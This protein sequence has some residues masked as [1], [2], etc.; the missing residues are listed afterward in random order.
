MKYDINGIFRVFGKATTNKREREMREFLIFI[1]YKLE[2]TTLNET[3]KK[4]LKVFLMPK[5][6]LKTLI[7]ILKKFK[8]NMNFIFFLDFL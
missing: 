4:M 7:I 6:L 3:L 2:A 1:K 8:F 5:T